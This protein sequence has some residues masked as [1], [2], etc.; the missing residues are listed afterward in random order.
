MTPGMTLAP[1]AFDLSRPVGR[2]CDKKVCAAQHFSIEVRFRCSTLALL[3]CSML[4]ATQK[5]RGWER[6]SYAEFD[7]SSY[8]N[9]EARFSPWHP[10]QQIAA[11]LAGFLASARQQIIVWASRAQDRRDLARLSDREFLDMP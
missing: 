8:T 4:G 2:G 6:R 11:T 7:M 1:R 5:P 3:Q 10:H 9:P